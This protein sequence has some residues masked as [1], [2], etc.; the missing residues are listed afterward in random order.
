MIACHLK[1]YN[2]VTVFERYLGTVS[3]FSGAARG[4]E[5]TNRA[6]SFELM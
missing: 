2:S 1:D 6:Q 4:L 5:A 3:R